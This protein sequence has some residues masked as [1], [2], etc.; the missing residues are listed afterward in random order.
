[1]FISCENQTKTKANN[2]DHG[3]A[4]QRCSRNG[5]SIQ[6]CNVCFTEPA[7]THWNPSL[8]K[9]SS[10][11]CNLRHPGK[12]ETQK[13]THMLSFL[14]IIKRVKMMFKILLNLTRHCEHWSNRE[15][16]SR[17]ALSKI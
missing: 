13:E 1:M 9:G 10:S 12:L 2:L 7:W 8:T 6:I 16:P 4:N 17:P 11:R 14:R 3:P 5:V 15:N